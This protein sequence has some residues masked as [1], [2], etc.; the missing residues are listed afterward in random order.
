[1]K[2]TA[3]LT[4]RGNNTLQDKNILDVLG[5]PVMYY[6]AHAGRNAKLINDWYCS[7]DDKKILDVAT[8]EGYKAIVRP[9]ELALPSAQHIDCIRHALNVMIEDNKM[10][11]ILVVLLANN[12][13]IQSN[14][15]DEC[16]KMMIED[17]SLTAVVPVY[18]D[19]DHHPLRGKIINENGNLEM[20]ER[21]IQGKVSTNRQDLTPCYFLSHNFWVLNV[22][23]ILS[24]EEGQQPWSF[25]GDKIKPYIIDESIDIHHKVDLLVAKDWIENHYIDND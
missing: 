15:I 22:P 5:H 14:W 12:V 16:V 10:P 8:K 7:S 25:M 6:P 21:G 3:L 4:G 13:T 11:D 24:G 18:E 23:Y 9:G 17:P 1:M 20:Y 2:V 19:N